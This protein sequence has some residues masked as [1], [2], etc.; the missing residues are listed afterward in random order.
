[1]RII[2]KKNDTGERKAMTE[3]R[4]DLRW[5]AEAGNPD[6]LP[7][8]MQPP[9]ALEKRVWKALAQRGLVDEAP[10]TPARLR[11]R[12]RFRRPT[13][14]AATLIAAS[15]L[16]ALGFLL[17]KAVS[18]DP[19]GAPTPNVEKYALLLYEG[20]SYDRAEGEELMARYD[21]YSQWVAKARRRGQFVTGE[22]LSVEDGWIVA[23]G[24][25]DG[26]P[27]QEPGIS[28]SDGAALSGL[29]VVTAPSYVEAVELARGLP[30]VRHGGEVVVQRILPTEEPPV[31][32][33]AS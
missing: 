9:P 21:E 2:S 13:S 24:E 8:E 14:S 25:A 22:D 6:D 33:S 4:E 15:L 3:E 5:P 17:G 1:M 30:H 26:P 16:V 31:V 32:P 23:P 12:G 20:R 18:R 10:S 29:F 28:S 27:R 7:S 19:V 11:L